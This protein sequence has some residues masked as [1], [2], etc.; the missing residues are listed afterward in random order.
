[1]DYSKI[2]NSWSCDC[3]IN[4]IGTDNNQGFS[5]VPRLIAVLHLIG[6][7]NHN[8]ERCQTRETAGSCE[9]LSFVC[10]QYKLF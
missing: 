2:G 1:M 7:Q 6:R 4:I 5:L 3:K 10:I 9:C 8:I